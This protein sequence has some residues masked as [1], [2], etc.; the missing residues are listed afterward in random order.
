MGAYYYLDIPAQSGRGMVCQ[1]DL[2][3]Q[4]TAETF[5]ALFEGK[6]ERR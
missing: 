5:E 6:I 2:M 1:K 3:T 4:G